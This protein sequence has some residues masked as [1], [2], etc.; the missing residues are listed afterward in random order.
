MELVESY[1]T[2]IKKIIESYKNISLQ[3]E[4]KVTSGAFL[5]IL[6]NRNIKRKQENT[7]E[8]E[9]E[10]YNLILNLLT[11]NQTLSRKDIQDL[12]GL[13]QTTCVLFLNKM[14]KMKKI[15]RIGKGKNTRYKI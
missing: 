6:P 11:K 8:L 9:N 10:K 5:L 3:P 7:E 15:K 2:G 12:L 4:F 14:E 1:G 13:K